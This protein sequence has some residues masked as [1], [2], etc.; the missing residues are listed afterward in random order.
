ML[1][2]DFIC[3]SIMINGNILISGYFKRNL[4]LYSIDID[5]FSI[6]PYKFAEYKRKILINAESL[7]LIECLGSIYKSEFRSYTNWRPVKKQKPIALFLKCIVHII[8]GLYTL[9]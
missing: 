6:I 8:K 2:V 1:K 5:S 9:E 3:H 4:L 7:Y